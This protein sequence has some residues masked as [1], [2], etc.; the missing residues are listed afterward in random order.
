MLLIYY[1][2]VNSLQLQSSVVSK[3]ASKHLWGNIYFAGNGTHLPNRGWELWQRAHRI[4]L[5]D[6]ILVTAVNN[7]PIEFFVDKRDHISKTTHLQRKNL[8]TSIWSKFLT[9]PLS[10]CLPIAKVSVKSFSPSS[11]GPER[12]LPAI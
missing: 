1:G 3:W 9:N 10:P 8:P 12:Y 7:S 2:Q 4:K 6:I 5:W 11:N